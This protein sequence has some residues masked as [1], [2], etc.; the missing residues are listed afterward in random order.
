[1]YNMYCEI[2]LLDF[3]TLQWALCPWCPD[4]YMTETPLQRDPGTTTPSQTSTWHQS[5]TVP[6]V[7][8]VLPWSALL[9]PLVYTWVGLWEFWLRREIQDCTY[10]NI[11]NMYKQLRSWVIATCTSVVWHGRTS[12]EEEG[13]VKCIH[14]ARTGQ[15]ESGCLH[16][17]ASSVTCGWVT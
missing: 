8:C 4:W 14:Q 1:M 15:P 9:Y 2:N 10:R 3:W 7:T 12:Q 16:K 11:T 17:Y 13:L 6:P 5:L